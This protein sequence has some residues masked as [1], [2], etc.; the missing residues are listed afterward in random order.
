MQILVS[1]ISLC[2]S[3][4]LNVLL[5]TR[6]V[7]QEN[8]RSQAGQE[9]KGTL[10]KRDRLKSTVHHTSRFTA[11]LIIHSIITADCLTEIERSRLCFP[12]PVIV[13]S[14]CTLSYPIGATV[15]Q[16]RISNISR[17][18]SSLASPRFHAVAGSNW[19][20]RRI[21]A[22]YALITTFIIFGI[23]CGDNQPLYLDK[24]L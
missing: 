11:L 10:P 23:S 2:C 16:K 17:R 4:S 3:H 13:A 1:E 5:E 15:T 6:R 22:A 8:P 14:G 7:A 9:R 24:L 19:T 12:Y 21:P 18:W 20:L